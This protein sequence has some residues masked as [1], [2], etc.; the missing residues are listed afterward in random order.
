MTAA[1]AHTPWGEVGVLAQ[2]TPTTHRLG[3]V[4]QV[5]ERRVTR[6]GKA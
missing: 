1:V 4:D 2:T 3:T 6:Y 5:A